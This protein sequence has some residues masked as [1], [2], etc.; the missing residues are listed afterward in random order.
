MSN[1]T[2][3]LDN[4]IAAIR[5]AECVWLDRRSLFECQAQ[6]LRCARLWVAI[7]AE[8]WKRET[9]KIPSEKGRFYSA[10]TACALHPS[11]PFATEAQVAKALKEVRHAGA[12]PITR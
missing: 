2:S 12:P 5:S 6:P 11:I 7:A 8:A 10:L 4:E 1:D 9:G 3:L